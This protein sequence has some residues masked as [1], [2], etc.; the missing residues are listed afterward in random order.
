MGRDEPRPMAPHNQSRQGAT[1]TERNEMS[2]TMAYFNEEHDQ[3]T[4]ASL[5]EQGPDGTIDV[6]RETEAFLEEIER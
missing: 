4:P 6:P 3:T 5:D 2:A 1:H